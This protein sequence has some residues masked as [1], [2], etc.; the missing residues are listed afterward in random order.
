MEIFGLLFRKSL[1][2]GQKKSLGS[3]GKIISTLHNIIKIRKAYNINP[4]CIINIDKTVLSHNIP[5]KKIII[6]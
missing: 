1:Y 4:E 2:I 3:E 5:E 6:K